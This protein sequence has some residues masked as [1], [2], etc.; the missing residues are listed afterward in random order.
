MA[1]ELEIVNGQASMMY[2]G[3]VPWHSLGKRFIEAPTL[4]EAIIA[5]GLNW[6]VTTEPL[7]AG[8][9]D[10]APALLTRR[11]SDKSI[12]GVVGPSYTPLQNSE[13]FNFFRPFIDEKA[14]TI[15]CAGSL[16][17]GK[18]VFVLC[19][20]NLA[21]SV[22]KGNDVVSKYLLLSNSHDGTLAV[23]V[24][25]TPVRCVCSN[26]LSM[27]HNDSA[28]K[29]IRVR[30]TG[31]VVANL[32][33]IRETM[34]LADQQFE[35]TAEQYRMLANKAINQS[36]LEKFV[37]LVFATKKQM[38]NVVDLNELNSG[39]RVKNDILRLFETGRGNDL[40]EIKGTYWAAYQAVT[41]YVQY[42]RGE[43][44]QARLDST[45]FGP[46]MQINKKALEVA[47]TMALVA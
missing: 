22:I 1:H 29:L 31:N 13:A 39:N 27:A 28:S 33:N 35:A 36:D 25:F 4:D 19:K 34:N 44:N 5:A 23:R 26:T 32:E 42:E 10:K 43:D 45:W 30:H 37:K 15:E 20:L 47:T 18:R 6:Q 46:G 14:A 11:D 7:F 2:V 21:D 41:E 8:N 3:D 17:Q 38:D 12:L 9:G 40:P 24:G 16:R